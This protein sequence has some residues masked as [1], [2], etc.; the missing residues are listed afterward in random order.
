MPTEQRLLSTDRGCVVAAAGCGKTELVARAAQACT[1]KRLLILTHTTAGLR[2]LRERLRRLA[3]RRDAATV[4]TIAGWALR[5]ARAFPGG[6]GNVGSDPAAAEWTA[7][8]RGATELM[9]VRSVRAVVTATYSRV[10]VD[11]YQDC[12]ALQHAL[13]CALGEI[14]PVCVLGDPLQGI[15]DFAGETIPWARVLEQFPLMGELQE[16]WRW[17]NKNEALGRWCLN[18]R[19]ALRAGDAIDLQNA[20]VSW[21]GIV[22]NS[23]ADEAY[24]VARLKGGAVVIRKWDRQA[25]AFAR[26]LGGRYRSMEEVEGKGVRAFAAAMDSTSGVARAALLIK[27]ASACMT[28]VNAAI[29][30]L[31]KALQAGQVPKVKQS[32]KHPDVAAALIAVCTDDDLLQVAKAMS[33]IER[34]PGCERFRNELWC[35]ARK[36]VKDHPASGRATV[37]ETAAALLQQQRSMGRFMDP[38]V[39]SRTLLVKGLEFEHA[40]VPAVEEFEESKRPGDGARHFYVAATRASRSLSLLSS[41]PVVRFS[42]SM[43]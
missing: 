43:Y 39:I 11:E 7:V 4:D 20:P 40:L 17:K 18:L 38:R 16:P 9:G 30:S 3:V 36:L 32:R 10:L 35:S 31:V 15:F 26:T 8:Y 37:I 2:A 34:L 29:P 14:L 33:A 19:D 28:G 12:D 21:R 41:S 22:G 27:F 13:I 5:Y 1:S 6:S 24:R 42:A 23:Q 25:H